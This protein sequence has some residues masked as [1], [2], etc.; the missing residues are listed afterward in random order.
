MLLQRLR[1]FGIDRH[2]GGFPLVYQESHL[3][4][5]NAIKMLRAAVHTVHGWLNTQ[6][7]VKGSDRKV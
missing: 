6:T 2:G 3:C 4:N 7:F 5:D 1:R